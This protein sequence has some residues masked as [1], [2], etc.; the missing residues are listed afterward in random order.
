MSCRGI[1]LW[2]EGVQRISGFCGQQQAVCR[3]ANGDFASDHFFHCVHADA[4]VIAR[5]VALRVVGEPFFDCLS[6]RNFQLCCYIVFLDPEFNGATYVLVR[7]IA[8]AVQDQGHVNHVANLPQTAKINF[9]RFGIKSVSGADS[10]RQAV[11]AG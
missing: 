3:A 10:H 11:D 5:I 4:H 6:K 8:R 2:N 1:T 7:D 9:W